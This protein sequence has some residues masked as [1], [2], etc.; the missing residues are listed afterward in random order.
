MSE[1]PPIMAKEAV[2]QLFRAAQINP[3]LR[4]Q[5]NQ[6][7]TIEQFVAMANNCGYEFTLD[8]WRS[9]TQFAVEELAS[10]LSEIPGL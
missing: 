2:T 6:S 3:S 7:A 4:E 9:M 1:A 8:E 10:E 5:L